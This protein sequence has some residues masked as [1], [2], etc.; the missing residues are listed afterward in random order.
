[1]IIFD[2]KKMPVIMRH[3]IGRWSRV[4]N[5]KL[6][7]DRGQRTEVRG[8]RSEGRKQRSEVRSQRS[9]DRRQTT[10]DKRQRFSCG[11]GFSVLPVPGVVPGSL[12]V[13]SLSNGSKGS[14]D[15]AISTNFLIF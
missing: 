12:P 3:F 2:E 7:E 4:V 13:L 10:E 15:L 11:S 1:M 9:E 14:R 8:Q 5:V 6:P